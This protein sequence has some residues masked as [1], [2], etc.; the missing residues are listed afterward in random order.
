MILTRMS[1][2]CLK[3]WWTCGKCSLPWIEIMTVII[4]SHLP[5]RTAMSLAPLLTSVHVGFIDFNELTQALRDLEL[6]ENDSATRRM[7]TEVDHNRNGVIEMG[8]Y[9][10]ILLNLK[11]N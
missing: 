1:N 5:S 7:M 4:I 10:D 11:F 6:Y 2:F 9:L 3:S 8:E